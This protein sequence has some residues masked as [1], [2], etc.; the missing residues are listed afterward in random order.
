MIHLE[1]SLLPLFSLT[2]QA[3]PGAADPGAIRMIVNPI[4]M[5]I[6]D[7]EKRLRSDELPAAGINLDIR[8][9]GPVVPILS[10]LTRFSPAPD[11][12]EDVL[13]RVRVISRVLLGP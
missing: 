10:V 4:E 3:S 13:E 8:R 11:R 7:V 9:S 12:I 1:L 6:D 2:L 5:R